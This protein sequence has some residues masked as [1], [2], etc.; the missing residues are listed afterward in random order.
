MFLKPSTKLYQEQSY[1]KNKAKKASKLPEIVREKCNFSRISDFFFFHI[2]EQSRC[3]T[4]FRTKKDNV[5][6]IR[7]LS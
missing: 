3:H 6:Y 2:E 1:T 5:E 4:E 7:Y